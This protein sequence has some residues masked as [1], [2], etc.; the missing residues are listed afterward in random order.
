MYQKRFRNVSCWL[1]VINQL[2]TIYIWNKDSHVSTKCFE[3][4]T[5]LDTAKFDSNLIA[6]LTEGMKSNVFQ[7]Q[8]SKSQ[9]VEGK[10]SRCL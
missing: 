10:V 3:H 8:S 5:N 6:H 2:R 7:P 4:V 9:T 1:D